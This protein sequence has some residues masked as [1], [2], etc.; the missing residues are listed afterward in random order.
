[1]A[2]AIGIDFGVFWAAARVEIEHGATA[3]FSSH[4]MQPLE[5][6]VR[7]I[8]N[9]APCP[10]PPTF[11]LA[12][13]PLGRLNYPG[14][15]FLFTALGI[16]AYGIVTARLCSGLQKTRRQSLIIAALAGVPLAIFAGQNSLF[17]AAAA[18]AAL[19]LMESAPLGA[20]ACLAVLAIKPQLG[21]LFPLA[22]ICGRKWKMLLAAIALCALFALSSV[23]I[24]GFDAW[25]A[26][27][28]NATEFKKIGLDSR[29]H[30]FGMPTLFA[31]ARLAG[32]SV[33]GAYVVQMIVAVPAA[34]AVAYLWI[35]NAR[36]ELKAAALLVASLLV[37]PYL[38][39]Y[40]LA[41]LGFAAALLVRDA[42]SDEL[43][44]TDRIVLGAVW[45]M[46]LYEFIG[47]NLGLPF[48]LAP[49]AMILMLM[50]I[51]R[52]HRISQLAT[53]RMSAS[54]SECSGS[55]AERCG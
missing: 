25:P 29:D 7:P 11:L 17:T 46:P 39:S 9:Y 36:R 14:A 8:P 24:L 23:A 19:M 16:C 2:P 41:W 32:L 4:W 33:T 52:R 21:V 26:F 43:T 28:S 27:L 40:D 53:Q 13:R 3:V 12:I 18:G 45:L 38:M 47:L 37:Q 10:Y 44:H 51:V 48:H 34:L 22:L 31:T 50:T 49:A 35:T 6:M 30:W 20:A 5:A 54:A 42:L 15:L 55:L 1:M